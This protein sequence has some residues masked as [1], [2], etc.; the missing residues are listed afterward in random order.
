MRHFDYDRRN[1]KE[2]PIMELCSQCNKRPVKYL[3]A[4]LC[5][6]CY[7]KN[8]NA[9]LPD[10]GLCSYCG[11]HPITQKK[12]QLCKICYK[13]LRKGDPDIS[14]NSSPFRESPYSREMDFVRNFFNHSNW[15]HQPASFRLNGVNYNP[16]FYDGERNTFIE[17]SGSRQAYHENKDK[18]A[19]FRK[20][21]PK[22]AFEIRRSDGVLLD[23]NESRL[24][25][26]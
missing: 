16:D 20:L 18:Y 19:K 15:Q 6:A 7:V 10:Y 2:E 26:Q 1:F 9:N 14:K 13:K 24:D 23:E 5:S 11:V 17:V 12:R 22:I 25:W 3:K 21:F 4:K 8:R